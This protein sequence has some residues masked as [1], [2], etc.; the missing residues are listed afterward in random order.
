MDVGRGAPF[1]VAIVPLAQIGFDLRTGAE[2]GQFASAPRALERA[3][4]DQRKVVTGEFRGQ[5]RG[6]SVRLP[7]SAANRCG[8]CVAPEV[9]NQPA[10]GD[11]AP[12]NP[13]AITTTTPIVTIGG[14]NA[15]VQFNSTV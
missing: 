15:Q 7:R 13:L 1:V 9:S 10:S 12:S 6:L 2:T 4:E 5:R 3:C 11:P 14:M 8:P